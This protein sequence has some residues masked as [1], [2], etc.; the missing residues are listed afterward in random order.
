MIK[1]TKLNK[2]YNKNKSNEIHVINDST[3]EFPK[4]GLV[5]IF[6]ESGCGKTTLLNVLGGLDDFHSGTIE[7][8][9]LEINKYNPKVIDRTRNEKI[10][11][12]FQNYLLLTQRTVYENLKIILDMYKLD[13]EE[14]ND[15][16][17]YVFR[18]YN[19]V[20]RMDTS[21]KIR[22]FTSMQHNYKTCKCIFEH[23][24][25]LLCQR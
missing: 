22:L 5:T 16:I 2:Y 18:L 25:C 12:I 8:D 17:D 4:T 1:I 23:K 21:Y 7:I 15:R 9:D 11:F 14:K 3:I 10:G 6:G 20:A 19:A 24:I 13:E